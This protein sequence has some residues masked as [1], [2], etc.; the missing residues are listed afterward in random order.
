MVDTLNQ[1]LEVLKFA[2]KIVG[3]RRNVVIDSGIFKHYFGEGEEFL[4]KSRDMIEIFGN[5][6]KE[7]ELEDVVDA[8]QE[9]ENQFNELWRNYTR[10][11]SY[12][13]E[14]IRYN[15]A[16]KRYEIMWGS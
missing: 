13:Y 3:L 12:C 15:K 11:R 8:F 4:D 16:K 10:G 9:M 6:D 2:A 5:E 14:G 7:I 1:G